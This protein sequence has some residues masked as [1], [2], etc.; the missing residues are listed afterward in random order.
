M[1][2]SKTVVLIASSDRDLNQFIENTTECRPINN[3]IDGLYAVAISLS[4]GEFKKSLE[5]QCPQA[6]FFISV[7]TD[8]DYSTDYTSLAS[9]LKEKLE[10]KVENQPIP[11]PKETAPTVR[12]PYGTKRIQ[13]YGIE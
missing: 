5:S 3:C 1:N 4:P 12:D 11:P 2:T 10:S 8:F 13:N 7:V 6:D 9:W